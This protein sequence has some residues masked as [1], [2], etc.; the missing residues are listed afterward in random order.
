[1]VFTLYEILCKTGLNNIIDEFL[2]A[3]IKRTVSTP[4]SKKVFGIY[5]CFVFHDFSLV[6]FLYYMAILVLVS[7]T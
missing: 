1:M 3:K 2:I 4:F 7:Q 5:L 6:K